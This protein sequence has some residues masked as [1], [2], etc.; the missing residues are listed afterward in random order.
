MLLNHNT[1]HCSD[2]R[3]RKVMNHEFTIQ[4]RHR[5]MGHEYYD[6]YRVF[7]FFK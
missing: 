1:N 2:P 5:Y 7:I 3:S 4:V 6:C